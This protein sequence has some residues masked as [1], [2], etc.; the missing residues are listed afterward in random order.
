MNGVSA[1][2]LATGND[3]RA[4]EAGAHAYA[5]RSGRYSA[6]TRWEVAK[7]GT[8]S[9]SLE[10]PLAVGIIGGATKIHPTAQFSLEIMGTPG[11]DKLA[12]IAGAVGLVQNFSALKALATEGIQRGHMSLHAKNVAMM[13]G[14][15]PDEINA[16]ADA[17]I[18]SGAV[19][20]DVA[21][22]ILKKLRS[23]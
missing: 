7:D 13:A 14:A 1:V 20:Q 11:A 4:V 5:A 17:L 21:K 10:M 23:K 15:E 9:G 8:L 3:T 16:V 19:R 2:V 22:R 18:E 6:L 12:R